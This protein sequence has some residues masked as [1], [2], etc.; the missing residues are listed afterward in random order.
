VDKGIYSKCQF[1]EVTLE[2][3]ISNIKKRSSLVEK[4]IYSRGL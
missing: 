1:A 2:E 3:M 4:E